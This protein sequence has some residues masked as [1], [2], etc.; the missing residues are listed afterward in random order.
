MTAPIG[1]DEVEAIESFDDLELAEESILPFKIGVGRRVS[2]GGTGLSSATL[3]TPK[4]PA[5]LNLPSPVPTLAQFRALEQ[6]LNASTQRVN[7]VQAELV[8]VRRELVLRRREPQGQTMLSLLIPL[9]LKKRFENHV[10]EVGTA[11]SEKPTVEDTGSDF[12]TF[13]P[14]LFLQ[15]GFFGQATGTAATGGQ[16]SMSQLLLMMVLME[17]L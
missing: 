8:K 10:H 5:K 6:A 13:L 14:I 7:A 9:M 17:A 1:Y 12:S 16:D 2:V 4:G 3:H 11:T 15:P